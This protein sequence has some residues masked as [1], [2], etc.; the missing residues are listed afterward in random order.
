MQLALL[1]IS[2]LFFG[3]YIS[4]YL[5]SSLEQTK[6]FNVYCLL[7]QLMFLSPL[8]IQLLSLYFESTFWSLICHTICALSLHSL[9]YLQEGFSLEWWSRRLFKYII[10]SMVYIV[11]ALCFAAAIPPYF[12]AATYLFALSLLIQLKERK[13]HLMTRRSLDSLNSQIQS[14]RTKELN[15]RNF[16]KKQL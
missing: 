9:L 11:F 16:Y 5:S 8:A 13:E 10:I 14:M 12:S 2:L 15:E 1:V 6:N 4:Y 7:S 3:F